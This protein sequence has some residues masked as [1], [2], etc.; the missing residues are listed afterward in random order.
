MGQNML[1]RIQIAI[2]NSSRKDSTKVSTFHLT[3]THP[4]ETG[5]AKVLQEQLH[6]P[7]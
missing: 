6:H 1:K 2:I 4:I 5:N 3:Q 7:L